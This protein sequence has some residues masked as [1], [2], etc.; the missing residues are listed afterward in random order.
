[1]KKI[2]SI[3]IAIA[4]FAT[5][6]TLAA[7]A[8]NAQENASLNSGAQSVLGKSSLNTSSGIGSTVM[9]FAYGFNPA[10]YNPSVTVSTCYEIIDEDQVPLSVVDFNTQANGTTTAYAGSSMPAQYQGIY[11]SYRVTSTHSARAGEQTWITTTQDK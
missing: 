5:I 9:T 7:F 6:G 3:I 10:D 8:Y 4:I 2:V 11:T 1:M